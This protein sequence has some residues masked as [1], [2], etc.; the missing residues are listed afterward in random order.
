MDENLCAIYRFTQA[1]VARA[2]PR[3][4]ESIVGG[5]LPEGLSA[6][7]RR[8]PYLERSE[9]G[10]ERSLRRCVGV[11]MLRDDESGDSSFR[12]GLSATESAASLW[13][14]PGTAP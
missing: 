11:T 12:I 5:P 2:V 10:V 8:V 6:A 13:D 1:M 7:G 4:D 3:M 9:L 14:A